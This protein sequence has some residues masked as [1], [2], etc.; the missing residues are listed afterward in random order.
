VT[1]TLSVDAVQLSVIWLELTT[2]AVSPDGAVG[3]VVSASVVA[4]AEFE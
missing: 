3:G 1:P 4:L 2:V